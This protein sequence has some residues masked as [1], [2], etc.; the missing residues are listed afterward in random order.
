MAAKT[1]VKLSLLAPHVELP[2]FNRAGPESLFIQVDTTRA[3][4]NIGLV[5]GDGRD[6]GHPSVG[7]RQP[8]WT[9]LVPSAAFIAAVNA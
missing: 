8:T 5:F 6:A 9:L 3:D 7:V 1:V 2:A 4:G